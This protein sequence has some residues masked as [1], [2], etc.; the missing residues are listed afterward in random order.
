M[1]G[2]VIADRVGSGPRADELVL[3]ILQWVWAMYDRVAGN[4]GVIIK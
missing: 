1:C 4:V 2:R 3:Q